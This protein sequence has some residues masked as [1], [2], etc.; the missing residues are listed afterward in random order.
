MHEESPVREEEILDAAPAQPAAADEAPRSSAVWRG[1]TR[2]L[3]RGYRA[4]FLFSACV[5]LLFSTLAFMVRQSGQVEGLLKDDF[6]LF[7]I[8]DERFPAVSLGAVE[9][10]LRALPHVSDV[11]FVSKSEALDQLRAADPELV[12]TVVSVTENPMPAYFALRLG[13]AALEDIG[14]WLDSNVLKGKMP[15][16]AGVS[17]KPEQIYAV[18]QAA[19]YRRFL[20]LAFSLAVLL[21]ACTAASVEF[22]AVSRTRFLPS[23]RQARNWMLSG[24]AGTAFSAG[25]CWLFV[26]PVKHLS[27]LWWSFPALGWQVSVLVC[28]AVCGWTLFRW[29]ESH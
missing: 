15:S 23:L 24:M 22:S 10:R 11:R 21:L 1:L 8:V 9:A 14:A 4:V 27:P 7:L 6:R 17:Y 20:Q 13:D 16:I 26:Y 5:G 29:K 18:M 3:G 28:G 19:F 25:L 12:K 2:S